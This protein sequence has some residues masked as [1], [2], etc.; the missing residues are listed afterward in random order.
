MM[1]RQT[2]LEVWYVIK[3][4]P[5]QWKSQTMEIPGKIAAILFIF[6]KN[7]RTVF[8]EY[9]IVFPPFCEACLQ[10]LLDDGKA[11]NPRSLVCYSI[12]A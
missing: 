7:A 12:C 1:E 10:H 6:Q 3:F 8:M 11:N 9:L 5:R 4:V 2:I